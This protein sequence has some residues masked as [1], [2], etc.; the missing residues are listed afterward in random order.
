MDEGL[1]ECAPQCW[2][3]GVNE[4][5]WPP[6]GTKADKIRRLQ[7][8]CTMPEENWKSCPVRILAIKGGMV[9]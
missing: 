2:L 1:I 9:V 7:R 3:V 6:L 5:K 8:S 4:C